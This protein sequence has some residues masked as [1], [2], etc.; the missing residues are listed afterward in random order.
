MQE[1]GNR[2]AV[3]SMVKRQEYRKDTSGLIAQ[4][5]LMHL[6]ILPTRTIM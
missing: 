5:L 1:E 3:K 2:S 6:L 4:S